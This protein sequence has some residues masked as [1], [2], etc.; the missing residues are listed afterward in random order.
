MLRVKGDSMIEE[1]IMPG[2]IVLV[3]RREQAKHGEIVIAQVDG[4]WTMK[5][6]C[7]RGKKVT[8][9][10]ANKKYPPI[11]PKTELQISAVVSAVIRK[12]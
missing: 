10:A 11:Q 12:Y 2:D 8:L 5:R 7:K 4:E 1:G 6:F 9:E 3:E